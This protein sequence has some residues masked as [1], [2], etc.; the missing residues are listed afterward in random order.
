[1]GSSTALY[2][3]HIGIYYP[4]HSKDCPKAAR[5]YYRVG[6]TPVSVNIYAI[7]L[8]L[9]SLLIFVN[10]KQKGH[11]NCCK[12]RSK[13]FISKLLFQINIAVLLLITCGDIH[14]NPGP[15][16][17]SSHL[18]VLVLNAQ[19]LKSLD[20]KVNKIQDLQNILYTDCP[21]V[22]SIC[23]TWLF[24]EE[25]PING[26]KSSDILNPSIYNIIRKDRPHTGGGVL[27]AIHSSVPSR[28]RPELETPS[29]DSNEINVTEIR[30]NLNRK[31]FVISC[32]KSQRDDGQKFL[33]NLENTIR[34]CLVSGSTDLLLL[35]D[36]NYSDLKWGTAPEANVSDLSRKFTQLCKMYGLTQY[37]TNPSRDSGNILELILSNIEAKFYNITAGFYPFKSDHLV[38]TC[39]VSLTVKKPPIVKRTTYNFR[40]ANYDNIRESLHNTNLLCPDNSSPIPNDIDLIWNCF[41]TNLMQIIN[42]HI[43]KCTIKNTK[44]PP[45][46]D[47]D[48]V[49]ASRKKHIAFRAAKRA[50]ADNKWNKFKSL[51]NQAKRLVD[52]K[53]KN[54]IRDLGEN[55][56]FNPKKFWSFLSMKSK[57][58]TSP[59]IINLEGKEY[60]E[61]RLIY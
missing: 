10:I 33:D 30:P 31:I 7:W 50:N 17:N 48:V 36:F 49:K 2:R 20:R 38:L 51:R 9:W 19:S 37:N 34:N 26:T 22:V 56:S 29:N 47:A 57:T 45:W 60:T 5:V 40:K 58:K 23:E 16:P 35:G 1:M 14:P 42:Q 11:R 41:H 8:L 28:E 44:S 24:P 4:K 18:T 3:F 55:L 6:I 27:T 53:Y 59:D 61:Q 21:H 39:N 52:I 46:I 15:V 54:F 43:P 13:L 32:Y 25:D 12:G